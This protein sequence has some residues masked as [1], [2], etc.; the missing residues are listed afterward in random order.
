MKIIFGELKEYENR[1]KIKFKKPK[2]LKHS[3]GFISVQLDWENNGNVDFC[4]FKYVKL[5]HYT[6]GGF[7][8]DSTRKGHGIVSAS[9]EFT[10]LCDEI[11][12]INM[13]GRD[14]YI[15]PWFTIALTT[16]KKNSFKQG[17]EFDYVF[18]NNTKYGLI[19]WFA[20]KGWEDWDNATVFKG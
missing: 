20:P 15:T 2:I 11:E 3:N 1:F 6:Y 12:K 7:A 16:A 9:F 4:D 5:A 10:E 18:F 17:Y 19:C 8:C 13:K 14:E